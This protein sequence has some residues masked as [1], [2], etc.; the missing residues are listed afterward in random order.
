[1]DVGA[2]QNSR[3]LRYTSSGCAAYCMLVLGQRQSW[4]PRC[5]RRCRPWC[6]RLR[7]PRFPTWLPSLSSSS[8]SSPA[9]RAALPILPARG[10]A[11]RPLPL[12]LAGAAAFCC[13]CP[14]ISSRPIRST[15]LPLNTLPIIAV[16]STH[17]VARAV[18][19]RDADEARG[20]PA[21]R[22]EGS[23]HDRGF[24]SISQQQRG[25]SNRPVIACPKVLWWCVS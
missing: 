10:A 17:V 22:R 4:L 20:W 12:H 18:R 15:A 6:C 13:R 7:P 14:D 16:Q 24:V 8:S 1:M 23:A 9:A 25:A 2:Q 21:L 11:A 19:G 5:R 3:V